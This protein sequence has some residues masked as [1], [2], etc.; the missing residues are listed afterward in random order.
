MIIPRQSS[1]ADDEVTVDQV[2]SC[3][4]GNFA[5]CSIPIS[6]SCS[7]LVQRSVSNSAET[8][9]LGVLGGIILIGICIYC[10]LRHRKNRAER[11]ENTAAKAVEDQKAK[12]VNVAKLEEEARGAEQSVRDLASAAAR[13]AARSETSAQKLATARGGP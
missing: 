4:G 12:A 13:L 1:A 8:S 9:V 6:T 3:V 11:K 10:Y 7:P 5:A 2:Q